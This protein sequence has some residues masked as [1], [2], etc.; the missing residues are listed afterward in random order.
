MY[1]QPPRRLRGVHQNPRRDI[2]DDND[3]DKPAE[4]K[5]YNSLENGVGITSQ[6]YKGVVAPKR[7][8][9]SG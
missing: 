4:D 5:F 3:W 1:N 8:P 2:G 6:A 7:A 9:A